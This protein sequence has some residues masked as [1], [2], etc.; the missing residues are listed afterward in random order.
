MARAHTPSRRR[1]HALAA[2]VAALAIGGTVLTEV[3]A[4]A[5][6]EPRGHDVSSHQ[7]NVDWPGAK[8]KGARFVYVKATE[9]HTYRNPYFRQQ[10]DGSRAA[11]LLRGAYH[12]ALPN[13]SSGATQAAYF[14]RN[15]GQWTADG[16]TL[17][18]A[19]DIEHNP[20]GD[21]KCYGLSKAR[22]VAWIKAFSDEVRRRSGRTPVIYTTTKWWND[23]TGASRAFGGHPLWLARW[24]AAPEPL[25]SG[26]SSWTFWQYADRGPLPGD[27]NLFGGSTAQLKRFARG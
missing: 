25:P 21:R 24:S 2:S 26:W 9:S 16:W 8:A 13:R 10:Y 5:A 1:A 14:L 19:L 27:Q 6:G 7:K 22:M 23:C 3:P 11:G 4:S 20:Y 18:P 17:P 15:G 12:F